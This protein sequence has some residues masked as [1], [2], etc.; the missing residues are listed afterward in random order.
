[1]AKHPETIR[2]SAK[3][4]IVRRRFSKVAIRVHDLTLAIRLHVTKVSLN[5]EKL[6]HACVSFEGV[7]LVR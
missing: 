5:K 1:M 3:Y 6:S 4:P 7:E 2:S